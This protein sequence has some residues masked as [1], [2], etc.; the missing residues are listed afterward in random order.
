[1]SRKGW[2][3]VERTAA[4]LIDGRRFPANS[5]ARLDAEGKRFVAQVKNVKEMSLPLIEALAKEAEQLGKNHQ[6]RL[7]NPTP[8]NG[9]VIIKRSAGAGVQTPHLIIMT[10]AVWC[11]MGQMYG[12]LEERGQLAKIYPAKIQKT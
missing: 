7:D 11:A 1:V 8:K 10:E 9:V 4:K 12:F 5:G 6:D 2:K 3:D